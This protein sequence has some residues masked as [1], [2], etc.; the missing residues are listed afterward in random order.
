[1]KQFNSFFEFCVCFFRS[2]HAC[3]EIAYSCYYFIFSI[4]SAFNLHHTVKRIHLLVLI[5]KKKQNFGRHSCFS[6]YTKPRNNNEQ[7]SKT[8]NE[9]ILIEEYNY[10]EES[11]I[12]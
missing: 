5:K 8:C 10:K 12:G 4:L 11:L 9:K 1:M 6:L 7:E 2:L 3:I